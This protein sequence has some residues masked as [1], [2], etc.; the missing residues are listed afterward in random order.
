MGIGPCSRSK[1]ALERAGLKLSDIDRV[2]VNEAFAGQYLAVEKALELD[3]N[4][5]NVNGGA[6]ALGHP[7]GASGTRLVLTLLH[8]L[9]REGLKYGSGNGLHWRWPG[10]CYDRRSFQINISQRIRN[11]PP[12]LVSVK[13]PDTEWK[14]LNGGWQG[15]KMC[16]ACRGLIDT[17]RLP[18]RYVG[19]RDTTP[20]GIRVF[21]RLSGMWTVNNV[22]VLSNLLIMR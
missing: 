19:H 20:N 9:R 2:E 5:T 11:R 8:E 18:V 22:L 10:H 12:R 4:K 21:V 16:R 7:L 15:L 13:S 14:N 6:I 17:N 3:R 1:I